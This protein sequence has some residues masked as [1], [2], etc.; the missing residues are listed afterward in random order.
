MCYIYTSERA[1]LGIT[2]VESEGGGEILAHASLL[3]YPAPWSGVEP[4]SWEQ[5]TAENFTADFRSSVTNLSLSRV[6]P[7]LSLQPMNT[8][9]LHLFVAREGFQQAAITE[10]LRSISLSLCCEELGW[11]Y[12]VV[13]ETAGLCL[14]LFLCCSMWSL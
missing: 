11:M 14:W 8:L 4:D 2:L 10:I 6:F 5:W 13:S 3:D 7:S 1:T 9:F 12:N